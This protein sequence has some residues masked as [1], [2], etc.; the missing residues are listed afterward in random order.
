MKKLISLLLACLS[1]WTEGALAAN[2]GGQRDVYI[3]APLS[4]VAVMAFNQGTFIGPALF[5]VVPTPK[6]SGNY[7]VITDTDWL[8]L[9]QSTTRAPEASWFT[10]TRIAAALATTDSTTRNARSF[11]SRS[12]AH[13]VGQGPSH[14]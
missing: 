1:A 12:I 4:N 10:C 14:N 7:Y 8:R 11:S 9:P 5:P 3:D 2:L 13:S 6:Q